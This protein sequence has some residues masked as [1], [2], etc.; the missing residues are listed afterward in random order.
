MPLC[1]SHGPAALAGED[2]LLCKEQTRDHNGFAADLLVTWE[3]PCLLTWEATTGR[4]TRRWLGN[5]TALLATLEGSDIGVGMGWHRHA[6]SC[7]V[8]AYGGGGAKSDRY[9]PGFD[10]NAV[11]LLSVVNKQMYQCHIPLVM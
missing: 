10:Y 1:C 7:I 9:R 5:A 11:G 6:V 8:Y 4:E 3:A 2:S